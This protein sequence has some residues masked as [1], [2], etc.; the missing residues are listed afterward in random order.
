VLLRLCAVV[1]CNSSVLLRLCAV[2]VCNSSVLLRLCA[3][4]VGNSSIRQ[5]MAEKNRRGRQI[6]LSVLA[7]RLNLRA[8]NPRL[9]NPFNR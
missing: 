1:V 2:V 5:N 3:V 9:A 8:E 7:V 4:V 6:L